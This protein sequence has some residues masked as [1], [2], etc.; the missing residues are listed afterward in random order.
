MLGG[1]YRAAGGKDQ[2]ALISFLTVDLVYNTVPDSHAEALY[3][4]GELWER[5]SQPERAREARQSLKTSY[6]VSPWAKKLDAAKS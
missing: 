6:P 3:N 2:D 5:G 1:I 4:L